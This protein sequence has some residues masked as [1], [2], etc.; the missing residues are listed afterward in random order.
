MVAH[1]GDR[2]DFPLLKA[3]LDKCGGNM[4]RKLLCADSYIAMRN[5]LE[6]NNSTKISFPWS[7]ADC[8]SLIKIPAAVG[9]EFFDWIEDN[10]Y[11]FRHCKPMWQII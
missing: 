2:F 4:D 7:E 8:L 5:S 10:N 6:S 1:N 3:E 11:K 9:S